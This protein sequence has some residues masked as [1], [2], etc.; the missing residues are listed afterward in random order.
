VLII[1]QTR[2]V[3]IP[4][5]INGFWKAF[6][7]TGLKLKKKGTRLT[8]KFKEPLAIDYDAGAETILAQIMDAIEQS[9]KFMTPSVAEGKKEEGVADGR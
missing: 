1:K 5:V 6:N 4:V 3:V 8:V 9:K 7:K 2:P